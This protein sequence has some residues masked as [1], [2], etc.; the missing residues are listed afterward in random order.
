MN[1]LNYF[2]FLQ[3]QNNRSKQGPLDLL[4]LPGL[5]YLPGLL[6]VVVYNQ[7]LY[8]RLLFIV[9]LLDKYRFYNFHIYM[10]LLFVYMFRSILFQFLIQHN[11]KGRYLLFRGPDVQDYPELYNLLKLIN[12]YISFLLNRIRIH[13]VFQIQYLDYRQQLIYSYNRR[14]Y[15]NQRNL[16]DQRL[17]HIYKGR[18]HKYRL[19][20][21]FNIVYLFQCNHMIKR[22]KF[23]QHKFNV[24]YNKFMLQCFPFL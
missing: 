19:N 21:K 24:F 23:P 8:C 3:N 12:P 13:N 14:Y 5:Y 18:F 7:F 4:Y 10:F 22:N 2:G 9:Y 16:L 6:Q 1:Y 17:Y 15:Y 20:L 11:A